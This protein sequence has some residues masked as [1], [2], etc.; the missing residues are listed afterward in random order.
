M[1]HGRGNDTIVIEKPVSEV[2]VVARNVA[3]LLH[4]PGNQV[5][6]QDRPHVL[7]EVADEAL[8][9][10]GRLAAAQAL[11][12][13]RIEHATK[14]LVEIILDHVAGARVHEVEQLVEIGQVIDGQALI[15][16]TFA[17]R[18]DDLEPILSWKLLFNFL[19]LRID[20]RVRYLGCKTGPDQILGPVHAVQHVECTA[21]NRAIR[22]ID[23]DARIA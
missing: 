23:H 15:N 13:F 5:F 6:H 10:H 11:K 8:S 18:D 4:E 19:D 9:Q 20:A 2:R 22:S 3:R 12:S 16:V 1:R 7:V 14:C 21:L 17:A